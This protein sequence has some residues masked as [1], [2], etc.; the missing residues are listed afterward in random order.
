MGGKIVGI[1][2]V[3]KLASKTGLFNAR[4]ARIAG[5][6]FL[7]NVGANLGTKIGAIGGAVKTFFSGFKHKIA[8]ISL[9]I[10]VQLKSSS[11]LDVGRRP[12]LKSDEKSEG[13]HLVLEIQRCENT[14]FTVKC[15]SYWRCDP[16]L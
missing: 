6:S 14:D 5:Q 15:Y 16:A 7:Q 10:G 4:E 11:D 8:S 1:N 3:K 9:T 12:E 13:I 2:Q